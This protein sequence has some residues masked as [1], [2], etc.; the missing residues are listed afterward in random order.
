VR[1]VAAAAAPAPPAP[2]ARK[3]MRRRK[4]EAARSSQRTRRGRRRRRRRGRRRRRREAPGRHPQGAWAGNLG[5]LNP[6]SQAGGMASPKASL[7]AAP[8]RRRR[9]LRAKR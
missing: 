5:R 1:K 2:A 4:R 3:R 8:V 7:P 6:P 9:R